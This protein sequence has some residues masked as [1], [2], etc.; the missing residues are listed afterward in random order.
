MKMG[1]GMRDSVMVANDAFVGKM[2]VWMVGADW[3]Q[4]C[5]RVH[6]HLAESS[7]TQ[8]PKMILVNNVDGDNRDFSMNGGFPD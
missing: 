4:G 2:R 7:G 5:R 3:R 6:C 8:K 1:D